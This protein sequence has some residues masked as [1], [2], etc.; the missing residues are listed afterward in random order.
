MQLYNCPSCQGR[1]FFENTRCSCGSEVAF[2]PATGAF[3]LAEQV[4]TN[5]STIHCNWAAAPADDGPGLCQSCL[6]TEVRPDP[7]V[8]DKTELW[9]D[10]ETAKRWVLANLARWGWLTEADGGL[11]PTFHMLAE[12][13]RRGRTKVTMGHAAGLVTINIEE[14]DPAERMKRREDLG[15]PLRTMIGH[16]RHEIA[17]FFFERLVEA[18]GFHAEFHALFGDESA[19]YGDALKVHYDNGPP[20]DWPERFISAYASAHPHEDWAESFA[21]MLHLIDITDSFLA[22]GLTGEGAPDTSFDAYQETDPALLIQHGAHLGIALNHVNRS[23]GLSDIYPF[24]HTD[25]IR[26]KLQFVHRWMRAGPP[27]ASSAPANPPS[28]SPPPDSPPP[29]S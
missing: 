9:S 29:A 20:D 15:E 17:H 7:Q 27:P 4:C 22:T 14:A 5:R 11:V 18:D 13:T 6:M 28:D 26:E 21:H 3:V 1:L 23:M 10:S 2:D 16:F 12:R 25:A 8:A 24:A 19:D